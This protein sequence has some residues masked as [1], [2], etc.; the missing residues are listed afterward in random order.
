[1]SSK[2]PSIMVSDESS[3]NRQN[4]LAINIESGVKISLLNREILFYSLLAFVAILTSFEGFE[5]SLLL[6][7]QLFFFVALK[8]ALQVLDPLQLGVPHLELVK[9]VKLLPFPLLFGDQL[10]PVVDVIKLF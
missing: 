7:L 8:L 1:M 6:H 5:F 10:Q 3:E 2:I 4:N 9:V